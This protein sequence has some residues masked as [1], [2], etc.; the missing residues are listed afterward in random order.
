[1]SRPPGYRSAGDRPTSA[2]A[3]LEPHAEPLAKFLEPVPEYIDCFQLETMRYRWYKSIRLPCNWKVAL[4][5]FNEG[6]HVA[7]AHPGL[8]ELYGR[9]YYDEAF[10]D[11]TSRSF[12]N[13]NP[14][15]GKIWSVRAYK[16]IL[17]EATMPPLVRGNARG[18]PS[19][20][21]SGRSAPVIPCLS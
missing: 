21:R 20:M 7:M 14:G 8:Q 10:R 18:R 19:L 5:A 13:F 6:Y 17:P 11:G 3:L 15:T 12:A 4:E 16:S 1:M 2:R 9:Y